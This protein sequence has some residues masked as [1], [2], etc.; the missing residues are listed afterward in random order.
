MSV[1][2]QFM[3]ASYETPM[4]VLHII[5][6]YLKFVFSKGLLFSKYDNL[7]VERYTNAN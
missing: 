4:L 7:E 2:N 3:H 1:V 5:L 6:K